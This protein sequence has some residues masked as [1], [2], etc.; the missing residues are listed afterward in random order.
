MQEDLDKI[1]KET[2]KGTKK[3]FYATNLKISKK[4]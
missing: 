3:D 1:F 2:V 4:P